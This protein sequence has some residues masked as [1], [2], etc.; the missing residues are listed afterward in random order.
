MTK[1]VAIELGHIFKLGTKYSEALG[2]NFLDENGVAKPIIMGSGN[3][4]VTSKILYGNTDAIFAIF[5][6]MDLTASRRIAS[7]ITRILRPVTLVAFSDKGFKPLE[8]TS[9]MLSLEALSVA[10]L[11]GRWRFFSPT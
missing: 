11:P 1:Q 3:A 8:S 7:T 9:C 10:E 6:E 4:E 2:A 5:P